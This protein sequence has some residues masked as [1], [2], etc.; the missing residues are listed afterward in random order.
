[1]RCLETWR[2]SELLR[3]SSALSAL[4]LAHSEGK[5]V[6][7]RKAHLL[8]D[9]QWKKWFGNETRILPGDRAED[10]LRA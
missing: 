5:Q 10:C 1:M 3:L 7:A 8:C 4:A 9:S 6:L 2:V